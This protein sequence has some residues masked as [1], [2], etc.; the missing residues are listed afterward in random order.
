MSDLIERLS[1]ATGPDRELDCEIALLVGF[2]KW[3]DQD[4]DHRGYEYDGGSVVHQG[5]EVTIIPHYTGSLDSALT[6]V[7]TY[8]EDGMAQ[9]YDYI[10]EHVNAG[11]TISVRVG[12]QTEPSF[13]ETDAL[14]LCIASLRARTPG[15]GEG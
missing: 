14:A 5:S 3:I 13:G 15:S 8:E 6:L 7:P 11:T 9:R 1:A 4:G 10:L 2:R 12:K